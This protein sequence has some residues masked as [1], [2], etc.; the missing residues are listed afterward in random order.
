MVVMTKKLK[1][2]SLVTFVKKYQDCGAVLLSGA[3]GDLD[4]DI[5]QLLY[6]GDSLIP[7]IAQRL[8][9]NNMSG[10]PVPSDFPCELSD[11]LY[12]VMDFLLKT[13]HGD[14][15][16]YACLLQYLRIKNQKKSNLCKYLQKPKNKYCDSESEKITYCIDDCKKYPDNSSFLTQYTGVI[17]RA[18]L[19]NIA[20]RADKSGDTRSSRYIDSPANSCEKECEKTNPISTKKCCCEPKYVTSS[21]NKCHVTVKK[22]QCDDSTCEIKCKQPYECDCDNS[23]YKVRVDPCKDLCKKNKSCYPDMCSD[24]CA[25]FKYSDTL[26]VLKRD[27]CLYNSL[28]K[29]TDVNNRFTGFY[30]YFNKCL[31]CKFPKGVFQALVQCE[32]YQKSCKPS[33]VIDNNSELLALDHFLVSD[34][35]K[36]N[37]V[38]ACLSDL[39]IENCGTNVSQLIGDPRYNL[40]NGLVYSNTF[41]KGMTSGPDKITNT[42][43][44]TFQYAGSVVK[45]FF[46]NRVYCINFDFPLVTK[47][48]EVGCG[49]TLHGLGLTSLWASM[50]KPQS[51]Y[52]DITMFEKFGLDKHPYFRNFF[53]NSINR[54]SSAILSS[55]RNSFSEN[56][57]DCH[58]ES[59]ISIQ[60]AQFI[61]EEQF[62][63]HLLSV[64]SD[65][66]S[67]DRFL[68]TISFMEALFRAD[69]LKNLVEPE[70]CK[71]INDRD[72]IKKLFSLL[73]Q[74]FLEKIS[75]A[76]FFDGATL[77][78][79]PDNT[80]LIHIIVN[81]DIHNVA[82]LINALGAFLKNNHILMEVLCRHATRYL[83][84]GCSNFSECALSFSGEQNSLIDQ[85]LQTFG[86]FPGDTSRDGQIVKS[87]LENLFQNGHNI[88][89]SIA[90]IIAAMDG[91][92]ITIL[93]LNVING[94]SWAA[95]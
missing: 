36:N 3:F 22:C 53:W 91:K 87:I 14:L 2:D 10:S 13:S 69:Q 54:Q 44:Y 61:T 78:A 19:R 72:L 55:S 37:I 64:F 32:E 40:I 1:V 41:I 85:L 62:Y 93:L 16:P 38:S 76:N 59:L 31:D 11:P 45:S 43:N 34:C 9:A 92:N 27:L 95:K 66:D 52:V 33:R 80:N 77:N 50:C 89:D 5:S 74:C 20:R 75:V 94:N 30:D 18:E 57:N 48:C 26:S 86:Y 7:E 63:K 46:T 8:L 67:R 51:D 56:L 58:N 49:E 6:R 68:V 24:P 25:N 60:K 29:I 42:T 35:L 21:E 84:F 88:S 79:N 70:N 39:H 82:N 81:A 23:K 12:E 17:S 90:K 4:Y 73:S 15:V 28:E 71:L 47:G 65:V 83:N